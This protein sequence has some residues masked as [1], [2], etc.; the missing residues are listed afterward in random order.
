MNQVRNDLRVLFEERKRANRNYSIRALARD[1]GISKTAVGDFLQGKRNLSY[2]NLW[3][4][5]ATLKDAR[6]NTELSRSL[7]LRYKKT[8]AELFGDWT[9]LAMLAVCRLPDAR[10]DLHWLSK[11][12]GI[13]TEEAAA[14]LQCLKSLK[15]IKVFRGRLVRI[16]ETVISNEVFPNRK[17]RN[18][19][20]KVLKQATR[21]VDGL[22]IN[23]RF[24]NSLFVAT[25]AN[26]YREIIKEI[27]RFRKRI[28]RI[29]NN[30]E[31][32][33]IY[34]LGIQLFPSVLECSMSFKW[35]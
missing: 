24:I 25:D 13:S 29:S 3:V 7:A 20:K 2:R 8:D 34:V 35:R 26:G 19:H 14:A 18:L 16:P 17:I 1:V 30:S 12:L 5:G 21:A 22:S 6:K 32:K 9:H 23:E 15:L 31:A 4:L 27:Y 11:T 10:A 28:T 33:R